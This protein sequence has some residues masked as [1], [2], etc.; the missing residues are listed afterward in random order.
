V[1]FDLEES[2]QLLAGT[3][4]ALRGTLGGLSDAW[5]QADE[6]PGTWTPWQTLAHLTHVEE[7][8]WLGRVATILEHGPEEVLGPVD[9]EAGFERFAGWDVGRV[10][11]RFAELRAANLVRLDELHLG[12]V[13]LVRIG[14]HADL[15]PVTLEQLLATWTVHDLNHETQIAKA[16]AKRYRDAVGPWRANLP[17]VDLP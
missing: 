14:R 3:P 1:T 8:D 12:N 4:M 7:R 13:D 16:L 6:G 2:R 11:D 17:V 10:L 5:L 15:G 9:R